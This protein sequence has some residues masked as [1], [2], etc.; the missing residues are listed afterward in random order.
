MCHSAELSQHPTNRR[1]QCDARGIV[2]I[3]VLVVTVLLALAAYGMVATVQSDLQAARTTA[4]QIQLQHTLESG[5]LLVTSWLELPRALRYGDSNAELSRSMEIDWR[6]IPITWTENTTAS[7]I[8]HL[9]I[10]KSFD[11]LQQI[12]SQDTSLGA[13]TVD[14]PSSANAAPLASQAMFLDGAVPFTNE[15][16]KLHLRTLREWDRRFPGAGRMAL[17]KFPGMTEQIADAILD[18]I[19][20]DDNPREFGAEQSYYSGAGTMNLPRNDIPPQLDELLFVRDVTPQLLFGAASQPGSTA[21]SSTSDLNSVPEPSLSANANSLAGT[22]GEP[23]A[24][25]GWSTFLTVWSAERNET[26]T[27]EPRININNDN[28]G[29]LYQQLSDRLST[30]LANYIV[31]LRQFG[32]PKAID[33]SQ[34]N[35]SF[36]AV[37]DAPPD[38]TRPARYQ[39]KSLVE[40]FDTTIQLGEPDDDDNE[41]RLTMQS[42]L[43]RTLGDASSEYAPWLDAITLRA[44]P[45]LEGLVNLMDAPPEVLA[46]IPEM[47][48]TLLSWIVAQRETGD[49]RENLYWFWSTNVAPRAKIEAVGEWITTGGDVVALSIRATHAAAGMSR[50]ASLVLDVSGPVPRRLAF[51]EWWLATATEATLPASDKSADRSTSPD[52]QPTAVFPQ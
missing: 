30:Q 9:S 35:A 17:M 4:N 41:D 45:R 22:L 21:A 15:S 29:E 33:E 47:D 52:S 32:P 13:A 37:P 19:D 50:Q 46:G 5:Q 40:L 24:G 51:G 14:T 3:I 1:D 28:L 25:A 23:I 49:V 43:R 39:L 8:G 38:L 42:P 27:G 20:E 2:L 12:F 16:A 10:A 44:E 31:A 6:R 48:E 7:E 36:A 18:W 11:E 26:W 34:G